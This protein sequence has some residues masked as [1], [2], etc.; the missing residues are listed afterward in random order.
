MA[1]NGLKQLEMAGMAENGLKQLDIA[2]QCW[3]GWEWLE[4]AKNYWKL[5][6]LAGKGLNWLKM[7]G[8][9]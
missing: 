3:N 5:L 1:R 8:T 4:I 2:W 7:A 9:A 6:K